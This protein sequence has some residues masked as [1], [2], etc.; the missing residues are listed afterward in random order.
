MEK[1]VTEKMKEYLKTEKIQIPQLAKNL[2]ISQEKL[3]DNN[4]EPLDAA[5]FLEL[6]NY[7]GLKP[8][9]FRAS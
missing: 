4:T 8:E 3:M 1:T 2:G 6:C 5:E 9:Q 7:L